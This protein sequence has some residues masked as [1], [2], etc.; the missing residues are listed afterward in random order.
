MRSVLLLSARIIAFTLGVLITTIGILLL[1]HLGEHGGIR[2]PVSLLA[3]LVYRSLVPAV[4]AGSFLVL[5]RIVRTPLMPAVALPYL[6]LLTTALLFGAGIFSSVLQ[7]IA[8]D[9]DVELSLP[10]AGHMYQVGAGSVYF[11]SVEGIRLEDVVLL[12]P[13]EQPVL[14]FYAEALLDTDENSLLLLRDGDSPDQVRYGSQASPWISGPAP[15]NFLLSFLRDVVQAR[16]HFLE[17]HHRSALYGIPLS[18]AIAIYLAASFVWIRYTRWPLFN[19]LMSLLVLRLTVTLYAAISA[20][21]F[22]NFVLSLVPVMPEYLV[23]PAVFGAGALLFVL[24]S[25]FRPKYLD[26]KRGV[27]YA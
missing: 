11:G 20:P 3:A 17:T 25:V 9:R 4:V 23:V 1:L 2:E 15:P 5:F 21:A 6:A 26:W 16:E 18:A 14:R 24:L 27:G 8:V 22:T 7:D 12:Q 19:V 13:R 10:S